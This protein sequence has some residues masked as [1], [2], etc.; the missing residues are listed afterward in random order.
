MER[1]WGRSPGAGDEDKDL[2]GRRK[3]LREP[4]IPLVGRGRGGE[5]G[6]MWQALEEE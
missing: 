3:H 2:G 1:G 5:G 6:E 4:E